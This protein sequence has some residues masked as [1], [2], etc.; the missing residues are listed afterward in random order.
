MEYRKKR[1]KQRTETHRDHFSSSI[2]QAI[3]V[4]F[5]KYDLD[6]NGTLDINETRAA[7]KD[8]F[9]SIGSQRSIS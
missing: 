3:D 9:M 2:R 6:R 7:L 4:I 1:D 5:T 8:S